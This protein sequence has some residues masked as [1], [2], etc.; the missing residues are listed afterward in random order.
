MSRNV[1]RKPFIYLLVILAILAGGSMGLIVTIIE[2]YSQVKGVAY[3]GIPGLNGLLI[4]LPALFLWIPISLLISNLVL[5]SISPLRRIAEQYVARSGHAGFA[6]SQK[7]LLKMLGIFALVC[8]PLIV[9][10]FIL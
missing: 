8:L 10:G 3:S 2:A 1:Q 5:Y 6:D 9:L 4:T 7:G